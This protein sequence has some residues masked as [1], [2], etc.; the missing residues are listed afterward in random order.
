MNFEQISHNVFVSVVDF[1]QI[2]AGLVL[3]LS[4]DLKTTQ[5]VVFSSTSSCPATGQT[6]QL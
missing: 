2:N 6:T 5:A 3:S 1:G 4:V